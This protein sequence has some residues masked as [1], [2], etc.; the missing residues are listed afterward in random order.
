MV[1]HFSSSSPSAAKPEKVIDAWLKLEL[2]IAVI[3]PEPV[4]VDQLKQAHN[5]DYVDQI[6]ACEIKNG[7]GNKLPEVAA[8][9]SYTVGSM[10]SAAREAI[11]NGKV[12]VAPCSGFHHAN[13]AS[14]FGYCTFNGLIV[15]AMVLKASGVVNKVGILDFDMHYGDGTDNLI[16]QHQLEWIEHYTAG[17]EYEA[18]YQAQEFLLST[19]DKVTKMRDCDIILYQ[20]GADPHINDPL[21]GLLTTEQLRMRDKTVF[22]TANALGIPIAWNLAGGYQV[23]DDGSIPE[24]LTIH[25]NTM[26]ECIK[27]YV[28]KCKQVHQ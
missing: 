16:E 1:A 2:P 26:L 12:A 7:F 14:A 4:T 9:L 8:S 5:P 18:A 17:Q 20:A 27:V 3:E 10:L 28:C 23:A 15:T 13:Y 25:S 19:P 22:E 6:L 24:I 11:C 21:G